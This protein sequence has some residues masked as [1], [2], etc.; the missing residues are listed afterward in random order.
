MKF[1]RMK[2]LSRTIREQHESTFNL[3]TQCSFSLSRSRS[4]FLSLAR[5]VCA[6]S[7]YSFCF[8]VKQFICMKILLLSRICIELS[9]QFV[10]IAKCNFGVLFLRS[11]CTFTLLIVRFF[12]EFFGAMFVAYNLF[13]IPGIIAAALLAYLFSILLFSS[14]H[15]IQKDLFYFLFIRWFT[16]IYIYNKKRL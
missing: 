3:N 10:F 16:C 9:V 12:V 7:V 2:Q 14:V 8:H 15:C 6:G 13:L 5:L 4:L 11:H 1:F